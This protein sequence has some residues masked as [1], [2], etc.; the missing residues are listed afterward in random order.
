MSKI[1]LFKN[2]NEL[3]RVLQH[4]VKAEQELKHNAIPEDL[5]NII[6]KVY[7]SY[8]ALKEAR[9]NWKKMHTHVQ[10][11]EDITKL[12]EQKNKQAVA[13]EHR[14]HEILDNNTCPLC[15]RS[16]K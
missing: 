6:D 8:D 1:Q 3:N 9:G 15:G 12:I 2:K 14:L 7:I 16:K 10:D 13:A 11:I 4:A 5:V